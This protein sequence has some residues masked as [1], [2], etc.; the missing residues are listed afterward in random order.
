MAT[1]PKKPGDFDVKTIETLAALMSQHELSEI[2]LREGTLHIRLRRG[3]SGP[4]IVST[5]NSMAVTSPAAPKPVAEP[6]APAPA[7]AKKHLIEVKSETVGTFYAQAKPTDPPFVKVGDRVTPTKVI[8]LVEVMKTYNE[9]QANC[10]G[11]VV[12]ILAV[13]GKYVEFGE[14]LVRVDPS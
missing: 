1:N 14:V 9:V 11:V 13:N 4:V 2:N 7:A 8:G 12:E 10:S 3:S 5:P 6:A